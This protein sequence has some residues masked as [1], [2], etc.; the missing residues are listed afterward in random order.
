M[1]SHLR[2]ASSQFP[3]SNRVTGSE[4]A[5]DTSFESVRLNPSSESPDQ[6]PNISTDL[7]LD[8]FPVPAGADARISDLILDLQVVWS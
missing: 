1:C 7:D 8:D 4:K 2:T 5:P 3:V 6:P